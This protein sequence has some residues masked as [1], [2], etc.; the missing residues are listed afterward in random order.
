MRM[1]LD[2]CANIEEAIAMF[3]NVNAYVIIRSFHRPLPL[4]DKSTYYVPFHRIEYI[5]ASNGD[6]FK[7]FLK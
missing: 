1:V 4:W 3:S 5:I 2:N 7:L 6:Y